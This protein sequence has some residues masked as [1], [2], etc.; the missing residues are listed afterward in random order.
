MKCIAVAPV[1]YK[2]ELTTQ[3]WNGRAKHQPW[4][5]YQAIRIIWV[6]LCYGDVTHVKGGSSS[7]Q[8]AINKTLIVENIFSSHLFFVSIFQLDVH[9]VANVIRET[10]TKFIN[11][12]SIN[13]YF[14]M[15]RFM[16][17]F[18]TAILYQ[19]TTRTDVRQQWRAKQTWKPPTKIDPDHEKGLKRTNNDTRP[20]SSEKD[21]SNKENRRGTTKDFATFQTKVGDKGRGRLAPSSKTT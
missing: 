4:K 7:R 12:I 2:T 1:S 10:K 9:F 8:H 11:S 21:R 5:Q 18:W 15:Y 13:Q 3:H 17:C 6:C 20:L 16:E 14:S 19:T